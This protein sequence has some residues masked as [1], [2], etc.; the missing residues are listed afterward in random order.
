MAIAYPTFSQLI[1]KVILKLN[2]VPGTGVQQYSEDIIAAHLQHAFDDVFESYY[3]PEYTTWQTYTLD[4]TLGIPNADIESTLKRIQDIG[5]MIVGGTEDQ[6]VKKLPINKNPTL[7]T[8]TSP[9][10]YDV[11]RTTPERVFRVYPAAS[12]GSVVC[13][14]RSK[15]DDFTDNDVVYLDKTLLILRACWIVAE[16]DG[17]NPGHIASFE[18]D[19]KSR[20][21]LLN[22]SIA[23]DAGV[24]INDG[25]V[26]GNQFSQ[27][28]E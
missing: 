24:S 15:P 6:V 1:Q 16:S 18:R 20:L 13:R 4:G 14:V 23:G 7:V 22:Q 21:A 8:G 3:W 19:Y 2:L 10:F 17:A 27:W 26:G 25:L 5:V 12:V 9:V 28:Q 11:Y